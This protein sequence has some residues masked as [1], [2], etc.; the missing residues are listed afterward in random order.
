MANTEV[1][2]LLKNLFKEEVIKGI[3]QHTGT[4]VPQTKTAV[5][6]AMPRFIEALAKNS[7]SNEGAKSLSEALDQHP[8][9]LLG[10]ILGAVGDNNTK[11]D[12]AKILEHVFGA[13]ER[14]VVGDMAS[15]AGI[16]SS[17]ATGILETVAPLIM[18]SLGKT[19][20][21]QGLDTGDISGLLAGLLGGQGGGSVLLNLLD[22]NKD[23]DIKD[24]LW[25]MFIRWITSFFT[26][27]R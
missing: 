8:G 26:S 13:G 10:N 6:T 27:K 11:T 2:N 20:K 3:S 9:S 12:G 25:T 16:S 5:K 21:D 23:G 19:K 4:E 1:T 17:Q 15:K 14:A 18:E 7:E 22:A 24:D